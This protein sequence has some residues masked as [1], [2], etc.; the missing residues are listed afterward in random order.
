MRILNIPAC[1][2]HQHRNYAY[3]TVQ[4]VHAATKLTTATYCN[5]NSWQLA[6]FYG[7]YFII[8]HKQLS[9]LILLSFM[10]LMIFVR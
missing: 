6:E 5:H 1:K 7:F 9:L 4:T 8:N 3:K 2:K 10:T